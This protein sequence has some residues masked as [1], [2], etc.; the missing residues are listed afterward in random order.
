MH[1]DERQEL[2]AA[3]FLDRP[4]GGAKAPV[5]PDGTLLL[6]SLAYSRFLAEQRL[7]CLARDLE[8]TDAEA[9]CIAEGLDLPGLSLDAIGPPV[10]QGTLSLTD[11][12]RS[13][14]IL[15]FASHCPAASRR[16]AMLDAVGRPAQRGS[17]NRG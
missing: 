5:E 8:L 15:S 12:A 7:R 9:A 1:P 10:R 3:V 6:A 16:C 2:G 13:G 11:A 17:A 4:F 14:P